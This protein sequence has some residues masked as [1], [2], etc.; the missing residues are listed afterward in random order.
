MK[1]RNK[2]KS[3]EDLLS[4]ADELE[5]DSRRRARNLLKSSKSF[6]TASIRSDSKVSRKKVLKTDDSDGGV[7]IKS[8]KSLRRSI[9]K[10]KIERPAPVRRNSQST[11]QLF[12]LASQLSTLAKITSTIEDEGVNI[13]DEL[14]RTT[15]HSTR[16]ALDK[17]QVVIRTFDETIAS[18]KQEKERIKY[19]AE[20]KLRQKATSTADL[21]NKPTDSVEI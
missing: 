8:S 4:T 7:S 15:S 5:E 19:D 1:H 18:I 10:K 2:S 13:D 9:R 16:E 12:G 14:L 6:D 20:W 17:A 21:N 3:A 11:Q